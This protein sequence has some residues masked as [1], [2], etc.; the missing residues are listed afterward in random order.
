MR[1]RWKNIKYTNV[2]IIGVLEGEKE[3]RGRK[4]IWR[5]NSRKSP[6]LGKETHFS[7]GYRGILKRYEP[8][9][10]HTGH[11]N[12]ADIKIKERTIKAARQ[13]QHITYKKEKQ[14]ASEKGKGIP[15]WM[16]RSKEQ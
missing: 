2:W 7:P 16:Q 9:Q 11:A 1:D 6:N 14:K 5:I 10:I 15:N 3:E 13:K 12:M 4:F 8:K